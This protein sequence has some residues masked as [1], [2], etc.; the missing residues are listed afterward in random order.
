MHTTLGVVALSIVVSL[1]IVEPTTAMQTGKSAET[2]VLTEP[3]RR[4]PDTPPAPPP[5]L[6]AD[7]HTITPTTFDIVVRR[8][9]ATTDRRA[10]R[11]T[12]SRTADR[13]HVRGHDGREWL[14]E[15]NPIDPRR[16][17]ATLVEHAAKVLVLYEETDLRMMLGIRGWADVLALGVDRQAFAI[18]P[19]KPGVDAALL[20]PALERFP[21]YRVVDLAE[22]LEK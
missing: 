19:G 9:P 14:F 7:A 12:I 4:A 8:G 1:A 6:P 15:R 17:S 2:W 5:S 10:A 11:H 20:R 13:I 16:V 21:K 18:E 22:W 3:K